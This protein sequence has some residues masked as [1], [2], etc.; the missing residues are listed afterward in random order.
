MS[1]LRVAK[2]WRARRDTGEFTVGELSLRS[3]MFGAI[4]LLGWR[5]KRK[6]QAVA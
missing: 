1:C 4:G 5:R 3:I 6:A 2:A